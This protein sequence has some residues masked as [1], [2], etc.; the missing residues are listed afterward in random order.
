[1]TE[2]EILGI[3]D[4]LGH[5]NVAEGFEGHHCQ[6]SAGEHVRDYEFGEDVEAD[7]DVCGGLDRTSGDL[8]WLSRL[9]LDTAVRGLE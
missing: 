9:S 6:G 3:D 2:L 1:M 7:L 4:A 5:D 8:S